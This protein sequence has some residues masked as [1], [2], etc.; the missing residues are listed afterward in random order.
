MFFVFLLLNQIVDMT[1]EGRIDRKH[2]LGAGDVAASEC[3]RTAQQTRGRLYA[4][5]QQ[6][7]ACEDV[8][9]AF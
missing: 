7:P 2:L 6:V 3:A 4:R 9:I 5:V 1:V 8:C